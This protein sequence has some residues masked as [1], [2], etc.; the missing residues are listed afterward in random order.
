MPC[1]DPESDRTRTVYI[2]TPSKC[3][4]SS[5]EG[6]IDSLKALLCS[7]C[8]ILEEEYQFNF[9]KNPALDMWFHK[10]KEDDQFRIQAEI[11]KEKRIEKDRIMLESIKNKTA[12]E[13]TEEEKKL[14][15]IK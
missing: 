7:A 11:E 15:G 13:L 3:D 2:K 9:A 10:H 8:T 4:H 14:L 1:Y 12:S 5:Y 6:R